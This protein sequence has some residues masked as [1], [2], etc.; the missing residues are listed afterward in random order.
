M[1]AKTGNVPPPSRGREL[2]GNLAASYRE[3]QVNPS[4]AVAFKYT[5]ILTVVERITRRRSTC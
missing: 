4:S 3:L 2:R 1:V 5:T